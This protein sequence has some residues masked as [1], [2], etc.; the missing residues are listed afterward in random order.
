MNPSDEVLVKWYEARD[1]FLGINPNLGYKDELERRQRGLQLAEK[2]KDEIPEA[3]WLCELFPEGTA[4]K[5]ERVRVCN[6]LSDESRRN[7]TA[8]AYLECFTGPEMSLEEAT[9][10]LHLG[11][12]LLSATF[13]SVVTKE[14]FDVAAQLAAQREP[15]GFYVLWR[16]DNCKMDYLKKAAELGLVI[17]LHSYGR[18]AFTDVQ[19]EQY[20]WMGRCAQRSIDHVGSYLDRVD[21]CLAGFLRKARLSSCVVQIDALYGE[22]RLS[23]WEVSRYSTHNGAMHRHVMLYIQALC[24]NWRADARR[25][26]N[27]WLAVGRRLRVVKD[28]RGV[29]GKR[30]WNEWLRDVEYVPVRTV[31][32][33]ITLHTISP[34]RP[35]VECT[36]HFQ[37]EK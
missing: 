29:I 13:S 34:N 23:F 17:A 10:P 14:E 2:L 28:I 30:I 24:K 33:P 18:N 5:L 6:R 3:K 25:A 1:A 7:S 9:H 27:A 37:R 20:L 8:L 15:R 26:V 22:G 36:M 4:E 21:T 35:V 11:E 31:C 16:N 12:I 19:P 32:R